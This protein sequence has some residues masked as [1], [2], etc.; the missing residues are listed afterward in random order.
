M[1]VLLNMYLGLVVLARIILFWAK[2][3]L[4]SILQVPWQ[5][6]V[7]ALHYSVPESQVGTNFASKCVFT[8]AYIDHQD[9]ANFGQTDLF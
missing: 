4:S 9:R 2:Y 8:K 1:S 3:C 5:S 7:L 6:G